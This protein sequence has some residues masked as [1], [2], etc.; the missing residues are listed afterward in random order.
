[1]SSFVRFGFTASIKP[2]VPV[3]YGAA[4]EDPLKNKFQPGAADIRTL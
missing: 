2:T 1:M 3:T 4:N